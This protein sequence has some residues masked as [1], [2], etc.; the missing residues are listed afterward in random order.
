MNPLVWTL[1]DALARRCL[2]EHV[3]TLREPQDVLDALPVPERARERMVAFAL[4]QLCR[5]AQGDNRAAVQACEFLLAR[6]AA[7]LPEGVKAQADDL[8]DHM[9]NGRLAYRTAD[10]DSLPG[11]QDALPD[12]TTLSLVTK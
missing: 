10:S 6:C 7:P 9:E 11:H 12:R 2:V 5:I 8:L 3:G 4:A 1:D